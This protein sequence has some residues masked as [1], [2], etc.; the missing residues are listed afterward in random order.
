MIFPVYK[1]KGKTSRAVLN[2]IKKIVKEKKVGHGGTLDPLAEGV[3]VVGVG[4]ESTKKLH[5]ED[6]NEK[7]YIATIFLGKNSTTDDEEGEKEVVEVKKN[8]TEEEVENCL[9]SFKGFLMQKPPFFSAVKV[10]GKESYKLAR[11]GDFVEL[12]KRKVELK[13]INI[14]SYKYPFLEI[15][16][17]T[18]RGFY[19]RS[20]ARDLGKKLK[21]GGYLYKLVRSRVGSFK[22][23]DC[24]DRIPHKLLSSENKS[25]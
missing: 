16:I 3:L 11:K 14:L 10:N 1:E 20:L 2:E 12:K 17:I 13:K 15:K 25:A 23:S 8:P 19:V 4:R 22:I 5:T 6:F 21:T 7:E 18:G 9:F 24:V